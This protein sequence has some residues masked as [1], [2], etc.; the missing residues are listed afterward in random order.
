MSLS[1]YIGFGHQGGYI[2]TNILPYSMKYGQSPL[3][4]LR[5]GCIFYG[6]SALGHWKLVIIDGFVSDGEIVH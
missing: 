5:L 2:V 4:G 6:I 1:L 3:V